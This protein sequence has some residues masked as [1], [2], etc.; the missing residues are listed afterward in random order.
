MNRREPP[1]MAQSRDLTSS[2]AAL[3]LLPIFLAVARRGSFTLAARDLHVSQPLVSLAIR[4]LEDSVG[5]TLFR[6][7]TRRVDLTPEGAHFAPVAARLL[8]DCDFAL[9]TVRTTSEQ[10][11]RQLR[12]ATV[13]SVAT[14]ILPQA[15]EAFSRL[16]PG[17]QVV[18]RDGNSTE[19]LRAV[20]L[21]EVD[22]GFASADADRELT[23]RSLFSDPIGVLARSDHAVFKPQRPLR[24]SDIAEFPFIG[25][26]GD[27]ATRWVLER[28]TKLPPNV[29]SPH[30]EVS[31]YPSLYGLLRASDAV[32][33]VPRLSVPERGGLAFRELKQPALRRTV[34]IVSRAGVPLSYVAAE[35]CAFVTAAVE[36]LARSVPSLRV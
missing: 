33:T 1:A 27:T 9:R 11:E 4:Q 22:L 17:V 14:K 20:R 13:T 34:S 15:I 30:Y 25:F 5:V 32:A 24:W 18:L 35:T 26:T 28:S 23:F 3:R 7:T 29:R 12:I 36:A 31:N 10:R 16:Y 6:R 8:L 19:V 21:D 2:L